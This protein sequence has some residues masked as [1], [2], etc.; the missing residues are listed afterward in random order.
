MIHTD[1]VS[2]SI[3]KSGDKQT[4]NITVSYDEMSTSDN[5]YH[6]NLGSTIIY[7]QK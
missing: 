6:L 3:L 5:E 7:K 4:F 2:G 1:E